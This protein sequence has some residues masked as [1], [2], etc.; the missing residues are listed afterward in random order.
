[1]HVA[2]ETSQSSS[3]LP[4]QSGICSARTIKGVLGDD[5]RLMIISLVVSRE[6]PTQLAKQIGHGGARVCFVQRELR[7]YVV[8]I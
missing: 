7:S 3:L 2:A 1:M 4:A 5:K 8:E 6:T